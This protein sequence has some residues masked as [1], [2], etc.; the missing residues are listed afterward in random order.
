MPRAR[1]IMM[2]SQKE[3]VD[4]VLSKQIRQD[5]G[6]G[7]AREGDECLGEETAARE[8]TVERDVVRSMFLG[9]VCKRI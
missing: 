4:P 9:D 6:K 5:I 7:Q 2:Q 1:E 3:K 8:V